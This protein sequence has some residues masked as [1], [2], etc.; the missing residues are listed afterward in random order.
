MS[1]GIRVVVLGGTGNIGTSTVQALASEPGVEEV[2][3]A[4]RRRPRSSFGPKVRWSHVDI[5]NDDLTEVLSGADAVVQLAWIF[6]PTH[7]PITTW[8]NNVL[9]GLRVLRA[10]AAEQVPVLVFA[11]SV[12]AYS[13]GPPERAVDESWPTDGWP[14]AAYS[15]EKAYLERC[16]DEFERAH[17]ATRVVRM[18][19]AFSFKEQSAAQQ[20]RLFLGPFV[21]NRAVR[22][23][24]VPIVPALPGLRFQ[25]VHSDDLGAAYRQAV[26]RSSAQ[27]AFNVAAHPVLDAQALANLLGART[28][29]VPRGPVR[30]ALRAAWDLHL[31]PASP[32]LFDTFLRL[33]IMD[34]GRAESLLDWQPER[35]APEAVQAFLRGVRTS[36]GADTPPLRPNVPGGRLHELRTGVGAR[37]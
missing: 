17:S 36:A 11:S 10:V 28:V 5:S 9:G 4:S 27:G 3:A 29:P 1:G 31:V 19:T 37:Q 12:A 7:D 20:R 8:R 18:R 21:P 2:V 34:T 33:P 22:P 26:L 16:L 24:L 15:R 32:E 35:S 23:S 13:P 30:G 14:G 25:A 6:Q